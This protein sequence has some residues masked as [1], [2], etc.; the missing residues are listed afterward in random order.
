MAP[1]QLSDQSPSGRAAALKLLMQ[2]RIACTNCVGDIDTIDGIPNDWAAENTKLMDVA[3]D[4]HLHCEAAIKECHA[5]IAALDLFVRESEFTVDV[6]LVPMEC[7]QELA[8][9]EVCAMSE[10]VA[11]VERVYPQ[12]AVELATTEMDKRCKRVAAKLKDFK[13]KMTQLKE[14]VSQPELALTPPG[15]TYG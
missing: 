7:R 5:I 12:L 14:M 1:I 6:Q 8:L 10:I 4:L 2:A 15:Q 9:E 3:L 13:V 11:T